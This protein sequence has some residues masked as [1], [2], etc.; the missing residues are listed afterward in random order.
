MR[1]EEQYQKSLISLQP[2]GRFWNT[3]LSSMLANFWLGVA[4]EFVRIERRMSDLFN[5][6]LIKLTSELIIDHEEDFGII[7]TGTNDQRKALLLAKKLSV[8]ANH[9]QY[10]IEKA[11]A[12]GLNIS[13]ELD[14]P[15]WVGIVSVGDPISGQNVI[16]KWI[17]WV[18]LTGDRGA[19]DSS[20]SSED[21]DLIPP[22]D[23]RYYYT[24][25]TQNIQTLIDEFSL[26]KPA[27]T[28]PYYSF[29]G[30]SFSHSFD[31]SFDAIPWYDG[32][33]IP[34]AFSREFSN[35]YSNIRD[36]DGRI[37]NGSYAPAFAIDFDRLSGGAFDDNFAVDYNKQH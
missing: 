22:N 4:T 18:D 3:N 2:K 21:F 36:Y 32:T 17:V 20:F 27:H 23:P 16:Y 9:D 35:D 19:F 1:I 31:A 8:G 26:Y 6:S 33:C 34:G 11:A 14:N 30:G 10:F 29:R 7:G 15:S 5:E 13:I 37:L 12:L 24:H 25:D 28:K